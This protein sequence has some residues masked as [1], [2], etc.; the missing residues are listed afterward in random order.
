MEDHSLLGNRYS[1]Q[2]HQ[3]YPHGYASHMGVPM[4]VYRLL[5]QDAQF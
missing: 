5:E 2:A 1:P 3:S 4:R